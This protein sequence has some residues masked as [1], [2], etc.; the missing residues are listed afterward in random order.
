MNHINFK[1]SNN[2]LP[3]KAG[4][5]SVYAGYN[6][7]LVSCWQFTWGEFWKLIK[8]RRSIFIIQYPQSVA[9]PELTFET[10][11]LTDEEKA[12]LEQRQ[13]QAELEERRKAVI[14]AKN[15]RNPARVRRLQQVAKEQGITKP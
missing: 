6:G 15:K 12:E 10:R 2:V 13:K 4:E 9:F 11:Q 3:T 8:N 14:E 7:E 5:M 1:N